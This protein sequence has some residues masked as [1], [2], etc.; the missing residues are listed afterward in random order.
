MLRP[1]R[2]AAMLLAGVVLLGFIGKGADYYRLSSEQA[3]LESRFTEEYRR[4]RPG[5]SREI[6]DPVGTVASLMRTQGTAALG[7]QLFLPSIEE[8]ARAVAGKASVR[9]EAIS[10]RAGVVDVR[11]TAPDIPTVDGIVQGVNQSGRFTASMQTADR[12]D[13]RVNSRIQIRETG[14]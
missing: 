7:P 10:Y 3:A 14:A 9:I 5:D 4:I 11:L 12:V 1:W 2:I 6:A 8:L 13:D